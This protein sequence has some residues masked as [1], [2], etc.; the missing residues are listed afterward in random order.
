MSKIWIK[1]V[2]YSVSVFVLFFLKSCSGSKSNTTQ[3][4]GYQL[5]WNDEF[6]VDGLPNK[7]NWNYE[8][9]FVRNE[10]AQWYQKENAVCKDGFLIIEVK[11]ETKPNPDFISKSTADWRKNR[12][13]IYLTSSCLITKDKQEWKY[14]RFEIKAKIPVEM[15]LWPAFWTLGV[16][17]NWPANGEIDI[18]EFYKGKILANIAWEGDKKWKP[19]W[20]S[21]T[22]LLESFNN[23]NWANEFH[24][25]RM[26]WDEKAIK[27]YV[28][29]QLLN[30]VDL[31]NTFNGT[32]KNIN[33]FH[34]SHYLLLNLAVGGMNGGDFLNTNFP[35]P[36]IIDYV[37]VYKKDKK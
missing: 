4:K 34:Q 25:W 31:S 1:S 16:E 29:N 6:N 36:F 8:T 15:G 35:A 14:G 23:N 24:I 19:V 9:G 28:D 2:F 7:N 11:K 37:R 33:P 17:H 10:E 20:D 13:S 18:M 5:I 32:N 26:D 12:D 3:V 27:L 21:K 30:E 22:Y